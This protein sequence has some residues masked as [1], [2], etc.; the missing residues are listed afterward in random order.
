MSLSD[1]LYNAWT[2]NVS[3][4][5]V[6]S[7]QQSET[8]SLIQAGADPNTAAAQAATDVNTTLATFTGSGGLGL[9]WTGALPGGPSFGSALAAKVKAATDFLSSHWILIIGALVALGALYAW[10]YGGFGSRR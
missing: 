7:L 5:Q 10:A 3:P 2:G 4:G 1:L 8:S 6:Q 9:S